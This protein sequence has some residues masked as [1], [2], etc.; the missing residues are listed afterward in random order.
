MVKKF[1]L[2]LSL[3][4]ACATLTAQVTGGVK[5]TIVSRVDRSPVEGASLTLLSDQEGLVAET[6]TGRDGTFLIEELKDG[7]QKH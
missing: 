4:L 3:L 1:T 7:I 2:A 5:G 6:T